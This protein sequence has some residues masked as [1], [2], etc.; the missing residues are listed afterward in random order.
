MSVRFMSPL[1][2]VLAALPADTPAPARRAFHFTYTA[3]IPAIPEGAR[4]VAIWIPYPADDAHQRISNVKL[5]G[6]ARAKIA[7]DRETGNSYA[8]FAVDAARSGPLEVSLTFD[9]VRTEY[10]ARAFAKAD[11]RPVRNDDPELAR[12]LQPD[13][14]V[15]LD[16]RVRQLSQEV[17][18][19]KPNDLAKAHAIYDYVVSTMK[20][21]KSGE[22]WGRGDIAWAC[23]A[24]RGNC[25]DFHALFIGLTR[26]AGIP[27]RFSIGFPLPGR[28]RRGRSPATTAGP[29]SGSAATAG[30]RWT[31]RRRPSIPRKRSTS[32]A[33]TT[34][35]ACSSPPGATCGCSRRSRV[36]PSTSSSTPTWKS[37]E[38]PGGTCRRASP[39]G[40][41]LDRVAGVK[42]VPW[43]ALLL[44]PTLALADEVFLKGAGSISG[45]IVEQTGDTVTVDVGAGQISVPMA[46]VE[47]ITEGK[48][49][50]DEYDARAARLGPEDVDGWKTLGNWAAAQGLSSQGRAAYEKVLAVAP[51]DLEARDAL[52]YVRVE[53]SGSPRRRGT[54]P[55][56][57]S[58]TTASG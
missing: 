45:R 18:A 38:S 29:S 16:A 17:T 19:G 25:T 56:G 20:Y 58:A 1:A 54:G 27:A 44:L 4:N 3:T 50:L 7:K 37:T 6:P 13:R 35:T 21:D 48:T 24:K 32:S 5:V 40:T 26:A 9:V 11:N 57:T 31:R 46:N 10:V 55:R 12:F 34:R 47:K 14:L 28:R 41:R 22:G 51:N 53:G 23:D 49:A 15:P 36:T 43:P 33:P 30:C 52:G 8:S 39:S 42:R 2:L